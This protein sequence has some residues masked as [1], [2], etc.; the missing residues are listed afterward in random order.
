MNDSA[1]CGTCTT[2]CSTGA[3]CTASACGFGSGIGGGLTVTGSFMAFGKLQ[4]LITGRP[5][6]FRG[7]NAVNLL[8]IAVAFGCFGMLIY[9]PDTAW[10]FYA[11]VALSLFLGISMVLPRVSPNL[12]AGLM[13]AVDRKSVV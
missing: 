1:H 12:M 3:T 2:V 10:A 8:L 7:Q 13:E 9:Q 6:T 11:M 5:I 4:E